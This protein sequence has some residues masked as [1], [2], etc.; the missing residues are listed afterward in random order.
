MRKL[1]LWISSL[2]VG[3]LSALGWYWA[4][5]ISVYRYG[6]NPDSVNWNEVKII[7]A[8]CFFAGSGLILFAARQPRSTDER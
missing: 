6:D 3:L 5:W 7:T 4:V 2:I 8:V 1:S